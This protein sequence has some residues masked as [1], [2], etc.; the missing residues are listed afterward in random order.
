[1]VGHVT[2]GAGIDHRRRR[3]RGALISALR[4]FSIA[5]ATSLVSARAAQAQPTT[6]P[7]VPT[8]LPPAVRV[9]LE[10]TRTALS[11]RFDAFQSKEPAFTARCGPGQIPVNDTAKLASCQAEFAALQQESTALTADKRLYTTGLDSTIAARDARCSTFTDQIQRDRAALLRQ[12]KV[13]EASV[14]ELE[15]WAAANAEAQRG[16]LMAGAS[17]LFGSAAK[18]L[19]TREASA[20][21]F[22]RLLG[23]YERQLTTGGVPFSAIKGRVARALGGYASARTQAGLGGLMSSAADMN[24]RWKYVQTEASVIASRQAAADADLRAALADPSVQRILQSDATALD[25][26]RSTADLA[27]GSSTLARIGPQYALAS[28]LVDYGYESAKWGASRARIL[29][30]AAF[31]D[32]E[33]RAVEAL[34]Q[35]MERS[36]A[37]LQACRAT[38]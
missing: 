15:Q 17:A 11:A 6:L 7:A 13:N 18:Q 3:D 8:Q 24:E 20:A 9:S 10:Q 37:R 36:V 35:Q 34:S 4:R 21:A 12:Q 1:M 25:L 32:Q 22:E 38:P 31:S 28:F 26:L 14:G 23:R 16:A 29:Q 5:V 30:G 33:L 27:A 19:E 2:S